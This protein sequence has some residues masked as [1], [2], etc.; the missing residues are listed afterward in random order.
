MAAVA[1]AK[2][3]EVKHWN[4][5]LF[6]FKT[7]RAPEFRFENGHFTMVGLEVEGKPALRAYSIASAN[8]EEELEFLSIKVADGLLTSRLQHIAVGD[9]VLLGKKPVGSLVLTD[10]HPGRYLYLFSTGTGLAPFMSIIR[11]PD[12]YARYEKIVLVHGVRQ[13]SDLAYYNYLTEELPQH[14]YL[15]EEVREKLLY[16]PT[17]TREPFRNNGRITDLLGSS[18]LEADLGLPQI[19]P[20]QDRAMICGSIAMLNDI[21]SLLDARGFNVSPS[22]GV[23]GDYVIE[24]AFVG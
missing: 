24:R 16:Y 19:D 3:T 15:G 9:E 20:V 17:V 5:R 23:A 22:Q 13:V 6:S 10:L 4:D 7:E 8:Y 11:D 1:P 18:K 14:E 21:S 12:A 2:V